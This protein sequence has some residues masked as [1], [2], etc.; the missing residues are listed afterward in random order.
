[1]YIAHVS[2]TVHHTL[3]SVHRTRTLHHVPCNTHMFWCAL[4][5]I[6]SK[7]WKMAL[8]TLLF[9]QWIVC[10][11]KYYF[12]RD[13]ANFSKEWLSSC[14]SM[15]PN[16]SAFL[17]CFPRFT[18]CLH[19]MWPVQQRVTTRYGTVYAN[20]ISVMNGPV[21]IQKQGRD[22][23][24]QKVYSTIE[25]RWKTKTRIPPLSAVYTADEKYTV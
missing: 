8:C 20:F 13:N 9:L 1:M 22:E 16:F 2:Q 5:T 21:K 3:Q 15:G 23:S 6:Q 19:Y 4:Y 25:Q 14:M 12:F 24:L 7:V 17:T 10:F 11:C 18:S